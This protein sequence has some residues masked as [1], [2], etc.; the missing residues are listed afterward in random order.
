MYCSDCGQ[1][2]PCECGNHVVRL[3]IRETLNPESLRNIIHSLQNQ[4]NN[5][6]KVFENS[7]I[8]NQYIYGMP[9]YV[10][11]QFGVVSNVSSSVATGPILNRMLTYTAT[12]NG[13]ILADTDVGNITTSGYAQRI[14]EVAGKVVFQDVTSGP[15]GGGQYT[16]SQM[17]PVLAGQTVRFSINYSNATISKT[18]LSFIPLMAL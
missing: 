12:A 10:N 1:P 15:I 16:Y 2:Y 13:Y 9:D 6:N 3:K 4:I 7:S 14:I 18:Q 17:V 5:L 8:T 11:I